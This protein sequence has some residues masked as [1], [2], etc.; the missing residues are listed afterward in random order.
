MDF[1]NMNKE[2]QVKRNK[3]LA[4]RL[5]PKNLDEYIG[6]SHLISKDKPLYRMIKAD[7]L[8]SMIWI[9]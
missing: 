3:P 4:A 2:E 9:V 1:F 5:R 7:K 8:S 6:Q